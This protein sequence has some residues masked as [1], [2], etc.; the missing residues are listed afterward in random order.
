M[1]SGPKK[2]ATR[3]LVL[4]PDLAELARARRFVTENALEAGFSEARVF[5]IS[6]ACSEALANAIEHAPVKGEVTVAALLHPD[7]LEL[8]VEGPG[9]FQ[10]PDRLKD[11][12][13]RGLGLPLMAKLSDHLALYSGPQ[14]GTLVTLSFYRPGAGEKPEDEEPLPPSI[15]ELI[16]QNA[17]TSAIAEN[18]PIGLAVLDSRLRF[19]W[20][21]AVYQSFL[22]EPFSSCDLTGVYVGDA[23]PELEQAGIL[24]IK[25]GLTMTR[26]PLLGYEHGL[27][28]GSRGPTWWRVSVVPLAGDSEQPPYDL[29]LLVSDE[30]ERKRAEEELRERDERMRHIAQAACIGLVEWNPARD[31]GYWSPEHQEILGFKP[32]S[33]LTWEQ[34]SQGLHPEDRKRVIQYS[35]MLMERCRAEGPI[36]GH[37][38]EFRFIRPDGRMIWIEADISVELVGG[39][40]VIR[41]SIRDVTQRKQAEEA[42]RASEERY[43][44]LAEENERLYRQQLDIADCLQ[45]TLLNV[46]SQIGPVRLGHL[47]R[48]A[49]E[50]ARV[51]GDFYDVFEAKNNKVV[52]LI[53]DVSGHGILAARAATM[54]KDVIH[55]F[56]HQTTR[57]HKVLKRTNE[58]LT[59]KN[60]EGFVTLFLGVLD[61]DTGTFRYASAGHPEA[62]L[63]RASG[64]I[65]VLGSGSYPLAVNPDA[66]WKPGITELEAGDLLLLYTDGVLEARRNGEF[67]ERTR[68]E[69]LL[70]RKRLS[71]ARLPRMVL[72][73]VLAFSGGRLNDDLAVLAVSLEDEKRT[74]HT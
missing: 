15:R 62:L 58:L 7:R 37:R 44:Q 66:S 23:I 53:G 8:Q 42:L 11:R 70:K 46:P 36:K 54:L 3:S 60:V 25:R 33:R 50:A 69:A 5:D 9:E 34:W 27:E 45:L 40:P 52:L 4:S 65:E 59:E 12:N 57:P 72:D 17:L 43:R 63:R 31:S 38:D 1:I 74:W 22:E 49:T 30:T 56:V 18:A 68:L 73:Q 14:G 64:E 61:L 39:E 67:F 28:R 10:T 35:A 41:N 24:D 47:Y 71:V 20:A 19:R 32:G 51:G 48:S 16:E 55:A 6:V 21:N 26:C 2:P 29:L 13:T